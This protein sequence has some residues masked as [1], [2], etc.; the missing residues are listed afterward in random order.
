MH[1]GIIAYLDPTDKGLSKL[2]GEIYSDGKAYLFFFTP[3]MSLKEG[4]V[5][6]FDL[7]EMGVA[8]LD[9]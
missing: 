1:K 9:I 5:V 3:D 2:I 7:N 6:K 8:V 4:D